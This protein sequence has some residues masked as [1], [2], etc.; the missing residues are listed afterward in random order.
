MS[1]TFHAQLEH[2]SRRNFLTDHNMR[3]VCDYDFDIVRMATAYIKLRIHK[4][5]INFDTSIVDRADVLDWIHSKSY[6][7]MDELKPRIRRRDMNKI[8]RGARIIEDA[9]RKK[10]LKEELC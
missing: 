1:Q 6:E 7:A 4:Q 5:R 10:Y 8:M 3:F 2:E 9:Y